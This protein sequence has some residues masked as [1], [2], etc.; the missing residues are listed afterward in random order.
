LKRE[1][2]DGDVIEISLPMHMTAERLPDQSNY[3]AMK[4]GPLVLA[5]ATGTEQMVGCDRE[6]TE[7]TSSPAD[8]CCRCTMHDA[9]HERP[10][11][12]G[13]SIYRCAARSAYL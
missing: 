9:G 12:D 1:W 7:A 10:G 4:Y 11:G 2:R 8:R 6:T 5:A 3:V 13:R